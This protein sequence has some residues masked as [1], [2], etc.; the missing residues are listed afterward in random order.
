MHIHNY[1]RIL[2]LAIFIMFTTLLHADFQKGFNEWNLKNYESA[3]K[4]WKKDNTNISNFMVGWAIYKGIGVKQSYKTARTVWNNGCKQGYIPSCIKVAEGEGNVLKIVNY[5]LNNA[6]KYQKGSFDYNILSRQFS[7]VSRKL[8]KNQL[9]LTPK[10]RIDLSKA[11]KENI[12]DFINLKNIGINEVWNLGNTHFGNQ[13]FTKYFCFIDNHLIAVVLY[14]VESTLISPN[15]IFSA[16]KKFNK[17]QTLVNG[18]SI[19]TNNE[20]LK[21]YQSNHMSL[22]GTKNYSFDIVST[23]LDSP[24]LKEVNLV[25]ITNPLVNRSIECN[26]SYLHDR[27]STISTEIYY[28]FMDTARLKKILDFKNKKNT[29]SDF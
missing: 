26:I 18:K 12:N 29:E 5:A 7:D 14:K 11:K 17:V 9:S 13:E 2:A 6:K 16:L 15:S 20:Y 21:L 28:S 22:M 23:Y 3:V 8:Y 27:N 19:K 1:K 10:Q 24:N 4:I 25:D